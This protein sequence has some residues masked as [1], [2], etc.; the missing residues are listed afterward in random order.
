MIV[1]EYAHDL[2]D[3]EKR[4]LLRIARATLREHSF[5]GRIPP[6]K[7]HREAL[8]A[9]AGVFVSL[10]RGADLRGCLGT[11]E[12]DKPLYRAIQEMA[13]AAATRDPRFSPV[14]E[15]ELDGLTIE[16]SVLGGARPVRAPADVTVG[17][18]GLCIEAD[19][20]RGLLLPQVAPEDGWDAAT[21]FARTCA[22]A[23][24]PAD[25]WQR[26][27]AKLIAFRAQV[28]SDQTHPRIR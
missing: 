4:E 5:S 27:D 20:R 23:G 3:D 10:Y 24:L 17:D 18:D 22:K 8:C 28:F 9:P 1:V 6:G 12:A 14:E 26:D 11:V 13:V 25:A 21:L 7:P 19:G 16:I 15:D 2:A